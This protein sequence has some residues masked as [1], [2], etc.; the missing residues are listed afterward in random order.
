M[1]G[2]TK[3]PDEIDNLTRNPYFDKYA[4][5]IKRMQRTSPEEFLSR[6]SALVESRHTP[7]KPQNSSNATD[8]R[9]D[10]DE[11]GFSA[12]ALPKNPTKPEYSQLAKRKLS[13]LMKLELLKDKTKDEIADIWRQ[14]HANKEEAVAAVIPADIFKV[15]SQ[16]FQEHKT[17]LFPLPRTT[18]YEFIVVQFQDN[19]AHFTTLLNYQAHKENA[20]ECLTMVNY[21]EFMEELGFVLMRGD[22]D[23]NVLSQMDADCLGIQM[24][25]Y[26]GSPSHQEGEKSNKSSDVEGCS[27]SMSAANI[28]YSKLAHLER[29]TH[30]TDNFYVWDLIAELESGR[31]KM[32]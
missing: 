3:P 24:L 26:Y 30:D 14:Y 23:R 21:T 7:K 29:F 9:G 12:V 28:S 1:A 17:F 5:K 4:D 8:N 25:Q 6:L 31:G 22:F 2:T 10:V 15:M 11:K 18:G 27:G 13:S 32:P 19:E 16:R 20:P